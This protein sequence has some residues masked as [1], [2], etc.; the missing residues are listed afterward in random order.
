VST[1]IATVLVTWWA[2]GTLMNVARS[3]GHLEVKN[4]GRKIDTAGGWIAHLL[5]KGLM[6]WAVIYLATT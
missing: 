4:A 6:I 2:L 3:I 1:V 5:I